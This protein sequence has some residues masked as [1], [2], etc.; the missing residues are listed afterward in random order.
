MRHGRLAPRPHPAEPLHRRA[1]ERVARVP[2]VE[3]ARVVV[4]CE[5]EAGV[6]DGVLARRPHDDA[7]IRELVRRRP[8]LLREARRPGRR[9]GGEAKRVRPLRSQH[10]LDHRRQPYRPPRTRYFPAM[11]LADSISLRS[12]ERKLRLFLE[13]L[14]PGPTTT[15]LDV[16][17][18][19]ARLRRGRRLRDAELLRGAL[20]VARAHHGARPSRRRGLPV[21][22]PA[23]P[24]RPGRRV[25]ASPS[26]TAQF[27]I[28]FSNAVIEHVGGRER[29]RAFVVG[30]DPGRPPRLHHDAEPPVPGR[31]AHAAPAR[32][33]AAGRALA[34]RVPGDRQGDR[35]PRSSS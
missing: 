22:L 13:E 32:P 29:Q 6:V 28:V 24:L 33:L 10:R 3:L 18:G 34:S 11:R 21:A 30:G 12:R 8:A 2:A 4:E 19:R 5:H 31:G 27:D 9:P 35:A 15:V 25:R 16:G 26:R 23:H 7:S 17:R 14:R 20:P 1:E